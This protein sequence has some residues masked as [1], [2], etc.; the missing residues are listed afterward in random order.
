MEGPS[1][2]RLTTAREEGSWRS[3][4][5]S[6]GTPTSQT[7]TLP[8][9]GIVTST[10]HEYPSVEHGYQSRMACL[11]NENPQPLHPG[12][13]FSLAPSASEKGKL[14]LWSGL[15][16][17]SLQDR[18]ENMRPHLMRPL[19]KGQIRHPGAQKGSPR[20]RGCL[21]SSR[22]APATTFGGVGS[23]KNRPSK[24]RWRSPSTTPWAPFWRRSG[25]KPTRNNPVGPFYPVVGG[26]IPHLAHGLQPHHGGHG[27]HILEGPHQGRFLQNHQIYQNP[28]DDAH[29]HQA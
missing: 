28:V 16:S 13:A 19:P 21:T 2:I 18:M 7:S 8:Y 25:R 20:H 14:A 6:R 12:H 17:P 10:G 5:A 15:W 24:W 27:N 1:H 23:T 22:L 3:A 9:N 26:F 4:A 29:R 11:A